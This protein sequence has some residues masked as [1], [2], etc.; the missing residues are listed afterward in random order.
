MELLKKAGV[1]LSETTAIDNA[2][3]VFESKLEQ[4]EALVL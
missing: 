2:F 1:D 4:F 3:D